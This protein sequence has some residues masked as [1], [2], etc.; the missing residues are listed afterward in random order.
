MSRKTG[1]SVIYPAEPIPTTAG[2]T[3]HI[4]E[5]GRGSSQIGK[6][7]VPQMPLFGRFVNGTERKREQPVVPQNLSP[8]RMD[9]RRAGKR[10][11][12]DGT[13]GVVKV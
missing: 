2:T 1:I 13:A 8:A 6:Q 4:D 10:L 9:S 3:I 11:L 12:D 5:I 7:L